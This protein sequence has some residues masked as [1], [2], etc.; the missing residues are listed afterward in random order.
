MTIPDTI[1]R[2]Y[3]VRGVYPNEVNSHVAEQVGKAFGT[4]IRRGG[5]K[6]VVV[7]CDARLSSPELR[8]ATIAGIRSTG[9]D[10]TDIG[11]VPTPVM[12]FAVLHCPYDGGIVVSASHNPPQYNGFKSRSYARSFYGDDIQ[13]F[14]RMVRDGDFESGAGALDALDIGSMYVEYIRSTLSLKK[15][16]KVVIDAGNGAS[17]PL[18]IRVFEALGCEVVPLFC[19]PDG[20]FPNHIPDPTV[21]EN[22]VAL[23]D[24]VLAEK[25]D[26]G[27]GLDGDGD[28]VAAMTATGALLWGD[29]MLA[30]LAE[31]VLREKSGPI[32]FD[33]K[34]SRSLIER[35]E[36]LGGQP[37]MWKTGYP[38]LQ[39]KMRETGAKLAGEMSGHM[40][41][42]DRYYGFD[43][44]T[45]SGARLV[46]I[47]SNASVDLDTM[48][49]ALPTYPSTPEFRLHCDEKAKFGVLPTIASRLPKTYDAV[50]VDGVRF[51]TPRGWGLLRVS[52]TEP[53]IVARFEGK[54]NADLLAIIADAL[55]MLDGLPVDV[56]PIRKFAASVVG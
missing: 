51:G 41:F 12:Y 36:Q 27:I 23:R 52:N 48:V 21:P 5:G 20:R 25:A 14:S 34:C 17:G 7:A 30:I 15:P 1:W 22:M 40:Y 44:G 8:P 18:A 3:D 38:L 26:M 45:Y 2:Q 9:V 6:R 19:E 16:L 56:S 39:A 54:E 49:A 4:V 31:S 42:A 35:I 47:V 32:V 13:D 46:E 10:V 24:K 37:I 43:D 53:A 28:R 33:V 11:M 29:R 50:T 55:K